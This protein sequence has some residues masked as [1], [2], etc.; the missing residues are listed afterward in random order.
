MTLTFESRRSDR[1]PA[2]HAGAVQ[3]Q[4]RRAWGFAKNTSSCFAPVVLLLQH[5]GVTLPLRDF[6]I[7]ELRAKSKLGGWGIWLVI[8][9]ND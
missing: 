5:N 2:Y 7:K 4:A 1:W 3:A 6:K 9:W 8:R